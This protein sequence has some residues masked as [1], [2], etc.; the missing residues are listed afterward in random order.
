MLGT[1]IDLHRILNGSSL[2]GPFRPR[3]D[4]YGQAGS[5]ATA[6]IST[7]CAN[8]A[9]C[10]ETLSHFLPRRDT[11]HGCAGW[12]ESSEPHPDAT[13]EKLGSNAVYGSRCAHPVHGQ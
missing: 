5:G 1:A 2:W 6:G 7:L 3:F 9:N 13:F 4:V 11:V 10:R 8:K 12:V